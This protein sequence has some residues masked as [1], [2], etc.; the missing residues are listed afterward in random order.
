MGNTTC[1]SFKNAQEKNERQEIVDKLKERAKGYGVSSNTLELLE[2]IFKDYVDYGIIPTIDQINKCYKESNNNNNTKNKLS[3]NIQNSLKLKNNNQSNNSKKT[4]QSNNK[5]N[6]KN[7]P[8]NILNKIKNLIP[9]K[10]DVRTKAAIRNIN[11]SGK[12]L[13]EGQIKEYLNDTSNNILT[14][15][16][17]DE[18]INLLKPYINKNKS[19]IA[20]HNYKNNYK[21]NPEKSNNNSYLSK[22]DK[23]K[24]Q[25][26]IKSKKINKRAQA[27]LRNAMRT[28][29]RNKQ[30]LNNALKNEN[31]KTKKNIMNIFNKYYK[32]QTNKEEKN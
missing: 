20:N 21:P 31:Q 3:K 4:I 25:T 18:I 9:N 30:T 27:T 32:S 5:K 1:R 7:I 26:Y 13:S 17:K 23:N 11:T 8:Q 22:N 10:A 19:K 15:N 29:P 2:P 28:I 24:L 6:N 16:K 12:L 14:K